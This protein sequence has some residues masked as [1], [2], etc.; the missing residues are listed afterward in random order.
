MQSPKFDTILKQADILFQSATEDLKNQEEDFNTYQAC[1][2]SRESIRKY[3]TSFLLKNHV[4]L[5]QPVTLASL[6]N[7]CKA[8][9]KKFALID[10]SCILCR[11]D[12]EYDDFCLSVEKVTPCLK[13]AEQTRKIAL[14]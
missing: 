10:M 4:E 3:F 9:D 1:N 13:V 14:G 5:N 6:F 12:S 8:I 11:H 7:Q 2:D